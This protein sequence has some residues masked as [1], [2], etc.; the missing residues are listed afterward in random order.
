MQLLTPEAILSYPSLV[1]PVNTEMDKNKPPKMRYKADLVFP[2]GTD[3]SALEAAATQ[4]LALIGFDDIDMAEQI[5]LTTISQSLDESG[6]MAVEML[7]AR[8]DDPG[9]SVQRNNLIL[10]VVPRETA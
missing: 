7:L 5:G 6:R 3:L 1:K 2:K 8:L 4:D 10:K 9:R